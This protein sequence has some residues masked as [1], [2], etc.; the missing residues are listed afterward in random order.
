VSDVSANPP[1]AR[2]EG[3]FPKPE[4][5]AAAVFGW[6]LARQM[7]REQPRLFYSSLLL[8][9]LIP[10]LSIA[11]LVM[12]PNWPGTQPSAHPSVNDFLYLLQSVTILPIAYAA[13]RRLFLDDKTDYAIWASPVWR[14]GSFIALFVGIDLS[15]R[16][17]DLGPEFVMDL[18]AFQD[19]LIHAL[20]VILQMLLL[21]AMYYYT[22][23]VTFLAPAIVIKAPGRSI[24][25]ALRES[26]G[27][28]WNLFIG[29]ISVYVPV[30]VLGGIASVLFSPL[31][32]PL[33]Q[34]ALGRPV[35]HLLYY[36]IVGM[37]VGA[38][39]AAPAAIANMAVVSAFFGDKRVIADIF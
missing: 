22:T 9:S 39:S 30:F 36:I 10:A 1:F 6:R 3:L 24:R 38:I 7:M 4:R 37:A 16:L 20:L 29:G 27:Q 17:L 25:T 13:L 23:K 34:T 28:F 14:N 31:V 32:T 12:A 19:K 35:D 11:L 2:G 21:A 15:I 5:I 8:C 18:P 33:L 26:K